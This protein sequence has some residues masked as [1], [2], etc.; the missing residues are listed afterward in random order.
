MST[1]LVRKI[2]A[3][4]TT[5]IHSIS[6]GTGKLRPRDKIWSCSGRSLVILLVIVHEVQALNA[7]IEYDYITQVPSLGEG[8]RGVIKGEIFVFCFEQAIK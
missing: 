5:K 6:T 7:F 2:L 8:L 3:N 4:S 1:H